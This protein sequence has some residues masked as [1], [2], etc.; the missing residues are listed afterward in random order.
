[1]NRS[2][3]SDAIQAKICDAFH[4]GLNRWQNEIPKNSPIVSVVFIA[5]DKAILIVFDTNLQTVSCFDSHRHS[6]Q[7]GATIVQTEYKHLNELCK[8]IIDMFLETYNEKLTLFELS[9]LTAKLFL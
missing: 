4:K 2:N 9:F 5:N 1:M 8:W 6:A 3:K 7:F